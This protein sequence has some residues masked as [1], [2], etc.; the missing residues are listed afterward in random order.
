MGYTKQQGQ[1]Y[2]DRY[3]NDPE[4]RKRILKHIHNSAMRYPFRTWANRVIQSHRQR[5]ISVE[6]TRL[7][8]EAL[9]TRNKTCAYCGCTLMYGVQNGPKMWHFNSA[10]ADRIDNTKPFSIENLQILCVRCNSAKSKMTEL[11]F[12]DYIRSLYIRLFG[13]T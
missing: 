8:L 6:I 4:F 10:S 3:H 13:K 7:E 11:E 12:L 9:A 1:H 5:G 2:M